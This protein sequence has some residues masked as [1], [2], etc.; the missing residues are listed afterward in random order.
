MKQVIELKVN[1]GSYEVAV[2][3]HR[4]LLEVLRD[5]IGFTGSKEGCDHGACGACTVIIDGKAVLACLT[6][7]IG[8]HGKEITTVEGMSKEGK[9]TPLQQNFVDH[10]ALQC[11]FCTPGMLMSAKALLDENPKPTMD[12][13]KDGISGNLCRCTGYTKILEA[14]AVTAK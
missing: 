5:S 7:A 8:A 9:L 3:P 13:I 2:D 11:G 4:T 10:G 6:L 14:I 12:E 1:G